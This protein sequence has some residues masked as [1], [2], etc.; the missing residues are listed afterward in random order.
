MTQARVMYNYCPRIIPF[1]SYHR[2]SF[3]YIEE[4]NHNDAQNKPG[5]KFIQIKEI[6]LIAQLGGNILSF[7]GILFVKQKKERIIN[8][9]TILCECKYL[10]QLIRGWFVNGGGIR[11]PI[12]TAKSTEHLLLCWIYSNTLSNEQRLENKKFL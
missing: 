4:E 6:P 5:A 3:C 12:E 8:I 10:W 9:K 1:V 11:C 7:L 2:P